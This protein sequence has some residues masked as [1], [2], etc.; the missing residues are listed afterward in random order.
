MGLFD[1]DNP[2][3]PDKMNILPAGSLVTTRVGQ[4]I[5][6]LVLEVAKHFGNPNGDNTAD[7]WYWTYILCDYNG[8]HLEVQSKY[9]KEFTA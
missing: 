8:D 9:F 5:P 4:C 6:R 7:H 2:P 1:K 3:S